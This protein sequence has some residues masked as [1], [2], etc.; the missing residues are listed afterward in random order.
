MTMPPNQDLCRSDN[1]YEKKIDE[2]KLSKSICN[3]EIFDNKSHK[4]AK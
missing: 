4:Q 1:T 2:T 3:A